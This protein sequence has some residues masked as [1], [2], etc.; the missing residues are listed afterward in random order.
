MSSSRITFEASRQG[1]IGLLEQQR[2]N[3]EAARDALLDALQADPRYQPAQ[4]L[5]ADL[6]C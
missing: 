3:C 2:G 5:L 1:L 6:D 4:R